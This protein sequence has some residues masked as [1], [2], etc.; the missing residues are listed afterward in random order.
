M[1]LVGKKVS[2]GLKMQNLGKLG[3]KEVYGANV[4][5]VDVNPVTKPINKGVHHRI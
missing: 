1:K 3:Q 4:S 5:K 2:N